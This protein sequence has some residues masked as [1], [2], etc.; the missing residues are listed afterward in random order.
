MT[1]AVQTKIAKAICSVMGKIDRLDKAD[2]NVFGKYDFT[3]VDDFKD[4]IRPLLAEHGLHVSVDELKCK[5]LLLDDKGSKKSLYLQFKY[6]FTVLHESGERLPPVKRSVFLQYTGAQT[7]GA[8]QSYALKEYFKSEFKASSGDIEDEADIREH[9]SMAGEK[10]AKAEARPVFTKLSSEMEDKIDEGSSD[11]LANWWGRNRSV[12]VTLPP[13][14]HI[15]L[16]NRYAESWKALKAK[17]AEAQESKPITDGMDTDKA[18]S[19]NAQKPVNTA[20]AAY[21]ELA[22]KVLKTTVTN[23]TGAWL[24]FDEE[25]K[26]RAQAG[27]S[28]TQTQQIE[29]AIIEEF[30]PR[31]EAPKEAAE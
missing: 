27:L 6:Q 14:W 12:I 24:W 3:S 19:F 5:Q 11:E 2:K 8:A 15:T 31:S 4:A 22:F 13:D 16:K 23:P 10:M 18:A 21:L 1:E 26:H 17:E 25:A 30:G 9:D 29:A 7:A 28:D 20:A